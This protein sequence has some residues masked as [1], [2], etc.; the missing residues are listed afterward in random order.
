MSDRRRQIAD[1][2]LAILAERGLRGVTHR[3]IDSA[4]GLPTGSTSNVFRTKQALIDG[5]VARLV[6][7]DLA[8]L[9]G[10]AVP[11]LSSPAAL[12]AQIARQSA[13][14]THPPMDTLTRA[15]LQLAL[16]PEI[17]LSSQHEGFT[18][19]AT[20]LLRALGA[21][22]P[23]RRACSITDYLDGLIFHALAMESRAF[24]IEEAALTL[25][26]LIG[27]CPTSGPYVDNHPFDD[28]E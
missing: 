20:Q 12:A 15:R 3:A 24:D 1:A 5:L 4:A 22:D 14:L 17:D 6:E 27:P 21:T 13:A 25:E 8:A 10:N 16:D 19:M 7:L 11:D 2:G 26:A 28:R 9:E 18:A 23:E